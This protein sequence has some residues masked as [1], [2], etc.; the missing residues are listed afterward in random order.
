[1]L[2]LAR[3]RGDRLHAKR[4]VIQSAAVQQ[5]TAEVLEQCWSQFGSLV[6]QEIKIRIVTRF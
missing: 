1:M 2:L 3:I 6:R 4:E 5:T